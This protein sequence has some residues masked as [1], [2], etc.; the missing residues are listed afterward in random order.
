[1]WLAISLGCYK[2]YQSKSSN[3]MQVQTSDPPK[4]IRDLNKRDCDA[5]NF[6]KYVCAEFQKNG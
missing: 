5:S 2:Y 6:N 1:M 3:A 4:N